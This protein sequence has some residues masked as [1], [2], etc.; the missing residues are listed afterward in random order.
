MKR[1]LLLTTLMGL[2]SG[3]TCEPP[4][5]PTFTQLRAD[6]FQPRCGNAAG[7]HADNPARGLDLVADP[8]AS[9]VDKAT[10][11]DPTKKYVVPGEPENS[12]LLTILRGPVDND[13]AG[14]ATRQMPP[15]FTLP[16]EDL[17]GLEAWIA[18]GAPND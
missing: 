2:L 18:S 6:I 8:F 15:G 3:G 10:I 12:L 13:D 16:E 11:T 1:A 17:A 5:A 4:P 14:L 7:C 9:L